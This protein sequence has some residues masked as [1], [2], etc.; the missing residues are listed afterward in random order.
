[1]WEGACSRVVVIRHGMGHH[2]DLAGALSFLKRDAHLN[3]VGLVNII[4][5]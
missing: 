3:D 2:N 1:M 5:Y 4:E